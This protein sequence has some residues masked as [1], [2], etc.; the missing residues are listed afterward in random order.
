MVFLL[1]FTGKIE[2]FRFF[3]FENRKKIFFLSFLFSENGRNLFRF[4]FFLIEKNVGFLGSGK[5][6]NIYLRYIFKN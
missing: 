4:F 2:K 5:S 3:L 1:I 6:K